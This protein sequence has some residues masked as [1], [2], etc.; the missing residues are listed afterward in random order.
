MTE[1]LKPLSSTPLQAWMDS[2]LQ[3]FDV[4]EFC[5]KQMGG[6]A[7]VVVTTF[8]TSEEFLRKMFYF[9]KNGLVTN[10]TLLTDFKAA[11]KTINL[12]PFM[13]S[14]FDDVYLS[15]NHSKVILLANKKWTVSICTS[16]NQTRGNR[17][18]AGIIT[19]YGMI[20]DVFYNVFSD[21][22]S[23]KSVNIYDVFNTP[24]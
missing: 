5:L 12:L 17:I 9:K 14:V 11:R 16:Q 20:Y 7:S 23:N 3:L 19:T 15:S 10:A 18:E 13:Q 24:T 6:N 4:M 22:I 1:P 21:L 2:G 8:S